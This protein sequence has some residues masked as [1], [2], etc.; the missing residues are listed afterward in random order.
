MSEPSNNTAHSA[1]QTV[2][3]QQHGS[4]QSN[5]M[6]TASLVLGIIA[7]IMAFIP[8]IGMI[9]WLL[10]PLGLIL[11]IIALVTGKG[12][13][14]VQAIVGLVLCAVALIVCFGWAALFGAAA[15]A[16]ASGST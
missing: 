8:L 1:G 2:I 4:G 10:A 11:G 5:G 3:V 9:S 13:G 16:G 6:A 12:T 14:K 15:A 7:L